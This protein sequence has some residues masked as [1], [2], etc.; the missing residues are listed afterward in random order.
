M[1]GS[2]KASEDGQGAYTWNFQGANFQVKCSKSKMQV[3]RLR[4]YLRTF[5]QEYYLFLQ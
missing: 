1:T 2:A 5:F 4:K 3:A